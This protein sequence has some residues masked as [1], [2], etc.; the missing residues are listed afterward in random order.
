LTKKAKALKI[1]SMLKFLRTDGKMRLFAALAAALA[2]GMAVCKDAR[3]ADIMGTFIV[4]DI[5]AEYNGKYVMLVGFIGSK[6]YI[7]GY[8]SFSEPKLTLPAISGGSVSI[9]VWMID[10]VSERYRGNDTF[11]LIGI[12]IYD[13]IEIINVNKGV[14]RTFKFASVKFLNG[15]AKRSYA[16][17]Q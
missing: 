17:R 11:I 15:S 4:T 13:T 6:L 1:V 9:P 7:R 5:P 16:D 3:A 14:L 2:L 8:D 10:N 12:V